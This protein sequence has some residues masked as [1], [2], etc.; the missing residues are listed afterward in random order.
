M[1]ICANNI[2][3]IRLL[4][5]LANPVAQAPYVIIK[6]LIELNNPGHAS[7]M[8]SES[9]LILRIKMNINYDYKENST[10]LKNIHFESFSKDATRKFLQNMSQLLQNEDFHDVTL[11]C[12]D[13]E[14]VRANKFILAG[15]QPCMY[16]YV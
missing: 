7:S 12:E 14:Q 16:V 3:P 9:T 15:K 1:S 13:D 2:Y 4:Q 11:I 8:D 10:A 5:E 6:H